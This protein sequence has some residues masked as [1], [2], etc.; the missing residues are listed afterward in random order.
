[1]TWD[2]VVRKLTSRKFWAAIAEFVTMLIIALKGDQETATQV[3]ALI[4]AGA[5]V[6]AY[7]VGEG[8]ADAAGAKAPIIH[9]ADSGAVSDEI[10][11]P[12]NT[13]DMK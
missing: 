11:P 13:D 2:D 9:I 3:A 8:L 12:E 7:I 10:K 1:M 4:M 5:A 6:V